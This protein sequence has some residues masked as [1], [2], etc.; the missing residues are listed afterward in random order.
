[1]KKGIIA[2]LI[3]IS[4]VG[5]GSLLAQPDT[6]ANK[7]MANVVSYNNPG[8]SVEEILIQ[9]S[10]LA[11]IDIFVSIRDKS[12]LSKKIGETNFKDIKVKY[13]MSWLAKEADFTYETKDSYLLVSK[14]VK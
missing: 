2:T 1:M 3:L 5:A 4:L 9:I 11:D 8:K 7:K 10:E 13:I 6:V 14:K 12:L